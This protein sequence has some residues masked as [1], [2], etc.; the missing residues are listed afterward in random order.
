MR[1]GQQE[2]NLPG[3]IENELIDEAVYQIDHW[4]VGVFEAGDISEDQV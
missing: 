1:D 2:A 4:A 3:G